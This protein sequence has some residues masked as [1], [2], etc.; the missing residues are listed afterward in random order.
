M[1]LA[2]TAYITNVEKGAICVS[3][4]AEQTSLR[5]GTALNLGRVSGSIRERWTW[6]WKLDPTSGG[7]QPTSS[8]LQESS[9]TWQGRHWASHTLWDWGLGLFH[10]DTKARW[11][12]NAGGSSDAR[13]M[14]LTVIVYDLPR[15]LLC[16]LFPLLKIRG[17][18][19]SFSIEG[20]LT[21]DTWLWMIALFF[22]LLST[23]H[24]VPKCRLDPQ[25]LAKGRKHSFL[26]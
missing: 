15:L 2:K 23:S 19:A 14:S 17:V 26:T 5:V 1:N 4:G 8:P 9:G 21:A 22:K 16:C 24:S 20:V 18:I 13:T 7:K 25:L 10:L 12:Q 11:F 6:S 3:F